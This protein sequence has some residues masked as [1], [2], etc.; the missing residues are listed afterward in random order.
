MREG[1]DRKGNKLTLQTVHQLP[2]LRSQLK[3][4]KG[5]KK[6]KILLSQNVPIIDLRFNCS[7]LTPR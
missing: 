3:L 1:V 4:K 7:P 2:V 6:L 5:T